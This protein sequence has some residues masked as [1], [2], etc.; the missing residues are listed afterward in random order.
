MK[1][2]MGKFL[3]DT[4]F[5]RKTTTKCANRDLRGKLVVFTGGTDGMGRLAVE[6]FAEMGA[7]ICLFGRNKEKTHKVI[8]H[9]VSQGYQ[10]KLSYDYL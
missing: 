9:I 1:K 3:L 6:R 8:E 2:P 5:A 4:F 7:N 10:G